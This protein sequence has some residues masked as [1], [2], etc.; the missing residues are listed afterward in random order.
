[1][2]SSPFPSLRSIL[3]FA[4]VALATPLPAHALMAGSGA[5]LPADSP[6]LRVDPNSVDSPW[7]GVGSLSIN[8]EV[9]SGVLISPR[10]VLTAAHV[11]AG[12]VPEA[13]RFNLNWG[14]DLTQTLAVQKV[15]RHPDYVGFGRPDL[16]YDLAILELAT[17]A[18]SGVP[19][20]DL[21]R[22]PIEA[23]TT[24]TLVGYGASGDG[25]YGPTIAA[26]AGVKRVGR[27][28]ADRIEVDAVSGR[29]VLYAFDFDA[30]A[31]GFNSVG[32]TSLGN[33]IE[34]T[35]AGGDSGSPAFVRDEDGRWRLAGIN[36]F[37]AKSRPA[38][39]A[40]SFGTLGGGQLVAG[41]SEW[42]DGVVQP[43]PAL[44]SDLPLLLGVGLTGIVLVGRRA[45]RR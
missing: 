9:Y 45:I 7:A 5:A 4:T 29:G 6:A 16:R 19:H 28:V 33:R 39:T 32:G 14:S 17:E 8:G 38:Q 37:Q 44:R 15:V 26:S 30:P 23:G 43:L 40:G 36:S 35:V 24:I 2:P 42:I 10:Y 18:P 27:N 20:Y 1:M 41:Y 13:I 21:M 22:T 11:V 25:R 12:V 3:V 34:T 31:A